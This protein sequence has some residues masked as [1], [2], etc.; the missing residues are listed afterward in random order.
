MET[1]ETGC[2]EVYTDFREDF[3]QRK[4]SG[5]KSG[6]VE[7]RGRPCRIL[8]REGTGSR[9]RKREAEGREGPDERILPALKRKNVTVIRPQGEEKLAVASH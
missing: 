5:M 7:A 4:S 3:C 6:K 8:H 2:T 9:L 1:G